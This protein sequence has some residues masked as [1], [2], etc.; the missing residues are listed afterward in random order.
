MTHPTGPTQDVPV[1]DPMVIPDPGAAP[2]R[3]GAEESDAGDGD[4]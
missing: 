2:I 3:E 1:P 4:V